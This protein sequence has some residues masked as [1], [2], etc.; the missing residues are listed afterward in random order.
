[1]KTLLR[2]A[3]MLLNVLADDSDDLGFVAR[4]ANARALAAKIK[5]FLKKPL[6]KKKN[7]S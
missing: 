5:N 7:L 3:A 4:A 6:P 2:E 1:M